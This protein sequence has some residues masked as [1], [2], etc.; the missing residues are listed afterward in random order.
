[1]SD[2]F[3]QLLG[4]SALIIAVIGITASLAI[5]LSVKENKQANTVMVCS[6][7]RLVSHVPAVQ[8]QG[9]PLS[10]C[11]GWIKARQDMLRAVREREICQ[12][13]EAALEHRVKLDQALLKE[14]EGHGR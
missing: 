11:V 9:E 7:T 14:M 12:K 6:I 5:S 2:L 8:F 1:M 3:A 4:G 13:D 10:N